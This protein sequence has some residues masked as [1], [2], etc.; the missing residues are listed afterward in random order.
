MDKNLFRFLDSF[1]SFNLFPGIENVYEY[2]QSI[3]EAGGLD[4]W[5]GGIGVLEKS[6]EEGKEIKNGAHLA[7]SES[8]TPFDSLS[9]IVTL[10][11]TT[12]RQNARFFDGNI[13]EVPYFAYTMGLGT[14]LRLSRNA[15]VN[16]TGLHKVDA[17]EASCFDEPSVLCSASVL[18]YHQ[19]A[20]FFVCEDI[21]NELIRR[22]HKI[23]A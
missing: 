16:A 11:E 9:G 3:K 6:I 23:A 1:S 4:V 7:F 21:G 17:V 14:I 5:M 22:G 13:D 18:Q 8:G 10:S 20:T 2:D 19:S 15:I 12:R